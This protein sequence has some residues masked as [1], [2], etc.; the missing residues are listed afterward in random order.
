[1]T[2]FNGTAANDNITG[3]ATDDLIYGLGGNDILYGQG[4]NDTLDGGLGRDTMYG[5]IGADFYYVD[6]VDDAVRENVNEG[7]DVILSTVSYSQYAQHGANVEEVYLLGTADLSA[8]GDDKANMLAGNT[9]SNVLFGGAGD[10]VLIGF[11]DVHETYAGATLPVAYG[12]VDGDDT[13]DGGTGRDVM[14]GGAGNDTYYVDQS[15]DSVV[16]VAS[17]G[18]DDVIISSASYVLNP[19]HG[20]FVES[21]Y[22]IGNANLNLTGDTNANYFVGNTGRNL[23]VG[24]IGNDSLVGF[25][26]VTQERSG[27]T[28][29]LAYGTVD[30]ADTL[31]GGAGVDWMAGGDGDDVY[32][33]DQ[34]ADVVLEFSGQGNDVIISSGSF[35]VSSTHGRNVESIYLTGTGNLNLTGDTAANRLYGNTG[36]N[37]LSGG[38]G[39]D[40]LVGYANVTTARGL[41]SQIA[42]GSVDGNDTLDGGAGDDT[43]DGGA[44]N[45]SMTGGTGSDYYIVDSASDIVQESDTLNGGAWDVV[46]SSVDFDLSIAATAGVEGLTLT[47]AAVLGKG[48]SLNNGISGTDQDNLLYGND[49]NDTVYGFG[50]VDYIYGGNGDDVIYGDEGD[51]SLSGG[52]GNDVLEGGSGADTLFGG[53]GNDTY[54]VYSGFGVD[55]LN[56]GASTPATEVDKLYLQDA[57]YNQLWFS[58]VGNNLEISQVNTSDKIVVQNWFASAN[59]QLD[60][61]YAMA[62]G[63]QLDTA[64]VA[65][66]VSAMAGFAPQDMS[67]GSTPAALLSA[68]D[69]AWHGITS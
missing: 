46:E 9:G 61:I 8:S 40:L 60:S 13:L 67:S 63:K 51:D 1:M 54:N 53:A 4:G 27:V 33:V 19:G 41:D 5:G 37:T 49:G 69:A 22:L 62:D 2:T 6:D 12:A 15:N 45:D 43:L 11:G 28:L 32:Y 31:D 3:A 68:R 14:G 58:Q 23:L 66:L 36:A 42:Y 59:S 7:D 55:T 48:N 26:D 57:S 52:A 17:E 65:G 18:T 21:V 34:A 44:G 25:G 38:D 64:K 50:G 16:E 56:N 10:D 24:G 47:G 29:P 39:N 30:G 35:T 20:I